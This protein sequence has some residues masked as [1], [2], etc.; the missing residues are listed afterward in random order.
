MTF[1][2]N[3]IFVRATSGQEKTQCPKCSHERRKSSDPCLSV[4]IDEGCLALPSLWLEGI[5]K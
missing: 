3:G 1:E 5:V 4:N 2:E